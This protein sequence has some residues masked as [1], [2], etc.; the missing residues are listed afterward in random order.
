M[1]S[2]ACTLDN[3]QDFL[4]ELGLKPHIHQV[5]I[6]FFHYIMSSSFSVRP[7]II[8]TRADKNWAHFKK[9]KSKFSKKNIYIYFHN[10]VSCPNCT[11]NLERYLMHIFKVRKSP[12]NFFLSSIHPKNWKKNFLDFCPSPLKSGQIKMIK[13]LYY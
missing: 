1:L 11:Q 3:I 8:I 10:V 12:K 5:N 4:N 7:T 13:A 6:I 2:S 9:S